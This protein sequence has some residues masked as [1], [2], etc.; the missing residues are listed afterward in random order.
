VTK[1]ID[2]CDIAGRVWEMAGELRANSHLTAAE[3][4][5][6]VLG[7]IFLKFADSRFTQAELAGSG[8][9]RHQTGNA[10]YEATGVPDQSRFTSA[11]ATSAVA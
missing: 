6:P 4:S 8:A 10:N 11:L 3:C 9:G 5:I 1:K 2:I 7:L